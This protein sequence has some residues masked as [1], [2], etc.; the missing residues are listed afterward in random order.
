M[1]WEPNS[2]LNFD[3]NLGSTFSLS[4]S[5]SVGQTESY[6]APKSVLEISSISSSLSSCCACPSNHFPIA[7]APRVVAF[8]FTGSDK[9]I[10]SGIL[11]KGT[12][13]DVS[14]AGNES[15]QE[16]SDDKINYDQT[17]Y[18]YHTG[19]LKGLPREKIPLK[20][21]TTKD[22]ACSSCSLAS[23]K[24]AADSY[25]KEL[26]ASFV[27]LSQKL[28]NK[29]MEI[30]Q[31]YS[32][33][34]KKGKEKSI[35][36]YKSSSFQTCFPV[37]E[38]TTSVSSDFSKINDQQK[39]HYPS[40]DEWRTFLAPNNLI[41][42]CDNN[43]STTELERHDSP[44]Y[45]SNRSLISLFK[46]KISEADSE[47]VINEIDFTQ[48]PCNPTPTRSGSFYL[49]VDDTQKEQSTKNPEFM[50]VKSNMLDSFYKTVIPEEDSRFN[51]NT[52]LAHSTPK[53][54]KKYDNKSSR[55]LRRPRTL[56]YDIKFTPDYS[57]RRRSLYLN[58]TRGGVDDSSDYRSI[59]VCECTDPL[60]STSDGSKNDAKTFVSRE[61]YIT[62]LPKES[63]C[64]FYKFVYKG[65]PDTPLSENNNSERTPVLGK[66]K[67]SNERPRTCDCTKFLSSEHEGTNADVTEFNFKPTCTSTPEGSFEEGG[68]EM[69][70]VTIIRRWLFCEAIPEFLTEQY[71]S[72]SINDISVTHYTYILRGWLTIKLIRDMLEFLSNYIKEKY[73]VTLTIR[74]YASILKNWFQFTGL[75]TL[76][77]ILKEKNFRVPTT[78]D[79][80]RFLLT[81]LES[82]GMKNI[83][84]ISIR[85]CPT[86]PVMIPSLNNVDDTQKCEERRSKTRKYPLHKEKT[87]KIDI[88]RYRNKSAPCSPVTC[89]CFSRNK[90]KNTK[91]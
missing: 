10:N 46:K 39:P 40:D 36:N 72:G 15:G 20:Q 27:E 68:P 61:D 21:L 89:H 18:H 80:H 16:T 3:R 41:P 31:E 33:S 77:D 28:D 81:W 60:F 56:K 76:L 52:P 13:T 62:I 88:Q 53:K 1:L 19:Q 34:S 29:I 2:Q 55:L 82:P 64:Q 86:N 8:P 26:Q 17:S 66:Q 45:Y 78:N 6:N 51:T 22:M 5:N 70:F 44:N 9:S 73:K 84:E 14:T 74:N 49:P 85:E 54:N 38:K 7:N 50:L 59:P 63:G 42:A 32:I 87:S 24:S 57:K 12:G 25:Q 30:L 69:T 75:Q 35:D 65:S 67:V 90:F 11:K 43:T 58:S 83:L 91:K 4:T 48:C 79:F 47:K 37:S 71:V 23:E